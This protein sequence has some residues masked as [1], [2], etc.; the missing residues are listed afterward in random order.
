MK[1]N[2]NVTK[3][4]KALDLLSAMIQDFPG[5]DYQKNQAYE[6]AIQFMEQHGP[7]PYSSMSTALDFF[8]AMMKAAGK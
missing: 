6:A 5:N 1:T 3:E 2:E 8:S 7:G 4:Q